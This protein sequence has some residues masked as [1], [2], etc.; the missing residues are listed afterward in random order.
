MAPA[1]SPG[2]LLAL[3]VLPG[4]FGPGSAGGSDESARRRWRVGRLCGRTGSV[5][6]VL[7][8]SQAGCSVR[9]PRTTPTRP[10]DQVPEAAECP[11][12]RRREK[13]GLAAERIA[14][15]KFRHSGAFWA[16]LACSRPEGMGNKEKG[17]RELTLSE[18]GRW[19]LCGLTQQQILSRKIAAKAARVKT[20][21]ANTSLQCV[22]P[23]G[24]R[25]FRPR[26]RNNPLTAQGGPWEY[27]NRVFTPLAAAPPGGMALARS[28][29]AYAGRNTACFY[30][31]G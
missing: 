28:R 9:S 25:A 23:G 7:A 21:P 14:K 8:P 22:K 11:L 13:D 4:S 20:E 27:P 30:G 10:G 31:H 12:G 2:T 1:P 29:A 24:F 15:G 5:S 26:A 6:G 18:A 3:R 19:K 16:V 17:P